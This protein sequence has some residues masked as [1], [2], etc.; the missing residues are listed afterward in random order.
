MKRSAIILVIFFLQT[1]FLSAQSHV[2]K[3]YYPSGRLRS[4]ISFTDSLR[5]GLAKF[6]YEN[7]NL[8]EERNYKNGKVE[9]TIKL[10]HKNG[11]LSEVFSIIDGI[12]EGPTSLYDST[13][14]YVGG[15]S[16]TSGKQEVQN[17]DM[18]SSEKLDSSF[19]YKGYKVGNSATGRLGPPTSMFMQSND[20]AYFVKLDVEPS[21]VGGMTDIYSKLVYP[22]E[23]LK[24]NIH[25]LVEVLAFIDENG[26]VVDMAVIKGLGYGCDEA[27][28]NAIR[29]TKFHPGFIKGAPVKSQLKISI[30]FRDN[31]N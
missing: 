13:G 15:L 18:E 6:Y 21:P 31:K 3:S 7:G 2:V 26:N 24:N 14:N 9:G 11:N 19:E 20:P 16:F 12:R 17:S 1:A 5:D 10:Y 30:Q 4:K 23:A 28:K 29:Y 27:A 22:E 8:K 25:G